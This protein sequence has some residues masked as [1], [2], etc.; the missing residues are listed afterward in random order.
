V[1][2]MEADT[3]DAT[4]GRRRQEGRCDYGASPGYMV[5]PRLSRPIQQ[6]PYFKQTESCWA[7]GQRRE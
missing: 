7:G 6:K 5:S 3:C 2:G 4:T 1:P